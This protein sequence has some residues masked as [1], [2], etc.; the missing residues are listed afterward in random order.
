MA[1]VKTKWVCQ[2]CGY[3]T[4]KYIGKCPDCNS[5]G[6]LVEE[7]EVKTNAPAQ[8][9]VIDDNPVCLI[10]EIE[11]TESI[12][13]PSGFEE[14][15]R[16]LG[17]GLVQGSLVLLAGDPGIGKSTLVLQTA[18]NICSQGKKL[19]YSSVCILRSCKD[20]SR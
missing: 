20:S 18:G 3:E 15:D 12:K 17:G 6:T 7:V 10:N 4:P 1:K 2:S 14:L 16:V 19:L 5:W 9:V 8:S 13:I 11:I